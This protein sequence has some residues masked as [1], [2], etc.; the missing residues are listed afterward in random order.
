MA[1]APL[2]NALAA[3]VERFRTDAVWYRWFSSV[4]KALRESTSLGSPAAPAARVIAAGAGLTGG[5]DLTADRTIALS[6]PVSVANGG[7][8]A[9]DAGNARANLGAA[10]ASHGHAIADVAGLPTA[11][12]GKQ[13]ADA[14]LTALA[15]LDATAGLVEQTGADAFTKRA[16]GVAAATSIPTRADADARYAAASH[17]HSYASLTSIPAALDA[18]DGLTPAAD[19][20]AYF[21]GAASAALAAITAF[22]RSLIAAADAAA[23]RTTLGLGTA[24]VLNIGTSGANV[25]LLDGANTWSATQATRTL[26][27]SASA[28]YNL[29]SAAL[30]WQNTYTNGTFFIAKTTVDTTTAGMHI[31]NNGAAGAFFQT[32]KTASG[33]VNVFNNYYSSGGTGTYVGG[34]DMTNTATVFNTSSDV[35][36][37]DDFQPYDPG[38]L[39]DAIEVYD[40]RWTTDGSRGIGVVAQELYPLEP[41]A[42][43]VGETVTDPETG[44]AHERTWGVDYSKLVPHLLAEVKAL[45]ARVAALES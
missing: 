22:G 11:L 12:D 10:A 1:L 14:T 29:G 13:A 3:L 27:P 37:K 33:T 36:L 2:P 38:A 26:E 41:R 7:T 9:I 19:F 31:A 5:G 4:D 25:P 18:I 45:R 35:R 42:V 40:F 21:T 16:I 39:F 8:G 15:G 32:V 23:A 44:E 20:F 34:I 17:S 30:K 24:A 43:S 6:V 28:T